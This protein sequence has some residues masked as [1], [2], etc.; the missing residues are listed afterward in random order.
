[1]DI[2]IA[3][4]DDDISFIQEMDTLLQPYIF[5]NENRIHF[6]TY[7][8]A[9][10]LIN[11]IASEHKY[12]ILL[13]DVE[14]TDYNGIELAKIITQYQE[15]EPYIVFISNYPEYMLDSFSVH[16]YQY[17]QKPIDKT[18]L[19]TTIDEITEKE[20]K[21]HLYITLLETENN[22]QIPVDIMEILSIETDNA[23]LQTLNFHLSNRTITTKGIISDWATKLKDYPFIICYKGILVNVYYIHFIENK[24]IVLRNGKQL[25]ISRK[26]MNQ[27]KTEMANVIHTYLI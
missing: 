5:N 16:P 27:I 1:M 2:N 4:C 15:A 6:D 3:L 19:Y 13:L 8:K 22:K 18:M 9:E 23:K 24:K 17:L 12:N 7:H 10:D 11:A 26:Y 20:K 14:I 25:P 21:R